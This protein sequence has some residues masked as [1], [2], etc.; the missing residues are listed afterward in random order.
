M[1][2]LVLALCAVVTASL[3]SPV[4]V[5]AAGP[6]H[7][8]R[9]PGQMI[10]AFRPGG[11]STLS[12]PRTATGITCDGV[13]HSHATPNGVGNN[14]L[15]ATA[16]ISP[17]D[18][19]AVGASNAFPPGTANDRTLAEHW[20]GSTWTIIPT[21]NPSS[22]FSDL[23]GV[24]AISTNNVWA[25]GDYQYDSLG[26][27]ASFA[28]H[29]NG[30]AWTLSTTVSP[31]AAF[32][33]LFA[34]SADTSGDVWAVGT[35]FTTNELFTLI[36]HWNGSS[37]ILDTS[38]SPNADNELFAVSVFSATDAWA[39]GEF[40]TF[41]PPL[42]SLALH[43]DGAN[44]TQ[45]ATGG[46]SGSN[47]IADV[48]ALEA[49]HAVGVGYGNFVSGS[50]PRGG[51]SWDL[52]SGGGTTNSAQ[53]GP[54]LGDNVLEGVAISGSGV[55]A[56][57]Y[58][59]AVV[60]GFFQTM[61][62]PATWISSTH[63]L[64]WGSVSAGANPSTANNVLYAVA[65]ITP[66]AFWAVGFDSG[67][68]YNQTLAESYCG[69]HFNVSAP[70]SA[71]AG[72]AFSVT[73][74]AK[75]P[76]GATIPG[77]QGTVHFTSG[78]L[79]ATLPGDYT[80]VPGDSGAHTFSG[81]VLHSTG[82][83]TVSAND[84]NYPASGSATVA[85]SCNGACQSAAGTPG[86][87]GVNQSPAGTPGPRVP[88]SPRAPRSRY[89]VLGAN[90]DAAAP[91]LASASAAGAPKRA[92]GAAPSARLMDPSV[93]PVASRAWTTERSHLE[94]ALFARIE[95]Q[96]TPQQPPWYLLLLVPMLIVS[97]TLAR[98]R[99]LKFKEKS[100]ARLRP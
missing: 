19:W 3:A 51:E 64:T 32:S 14:Y 59:Q 25:V 61:V 69:L 95:P 8:P 41:A 45:V 96:S 21:P 88:S 58:S 15:F 53:P 94:S 38:P 78:D 55:F 28:E 22:F 13:F 89:G 76:G 50:V 31:S 23:N 52:L 70:A 10:G 60:N 9:S 12:R 30:T 97:E 40:S 1:R 86:G 42:Q 18:I 47:L 44:W 24:A 20:N 80:F 65:A 98:R 74:T 77:Y 56:V 7:N 36:E 29:W 6:T 71:F 54:G 93:G 81:V 11:A 79:S 83:Q 26:D 72:G 33:A 82:N 46:L 43:W 57:G 62:R 49:N 91:L 37:W 73:V 34:V 84:T 2:K 100:N 68:V 16:A 90:A 27:V 99:R 66:F 75:D 85:V 63:T 92:P 17:S 67:S 35:L 4:G 5:L 48:K 87:R 39:V